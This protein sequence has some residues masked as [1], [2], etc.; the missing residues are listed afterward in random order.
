MT[1][2]IWFFTL[3]HYLHKRYR[4]INTVALFVFFHQIVMVQKQIFYLH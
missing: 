3:G 2:R 4:K 1:T